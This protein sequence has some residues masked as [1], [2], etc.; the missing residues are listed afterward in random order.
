MAAISGS[1]LIDCLYI[2]DFIGSGTKMVFENTNAPTSWTKDT[3]HNN[4][5]LRIIN[6]TISNGGSQ[7]FSSV[8]TT[9]SF[10]SFTPSVS[11][12]GSLQ[13]IGPGI[14]LNDSPFGLGSVAQVA[15]TNPP[16]EHSYQIMSQGQRLTGALASFATPYTSTGTASIGLNGQH[17]HSIGP[18]VIP[19]QHAHE[20]Q[21]AGGLGPNHTHST[22]ES[23]HSHSMQFSQSYSVYYRDVIIATKD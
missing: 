20:S 21:G 4:K 7:N 1:S 11:T 18:E 5:A 19:V 13:P 2:P 10:S 9:K 3:T 12:G 14:A 23:P 22:T 16:H 6:G 15:A 8:F 17:S